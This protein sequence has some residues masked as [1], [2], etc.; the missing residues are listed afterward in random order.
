MLA[1]HGD[2]GVLYNVLELLSARQHGIGAK[3][4]VVDDGGYGILR[5][6][7]E[8]AYGRTSKVDLAQPDFPALAALAR[9]PGLRGRAR[10]RSPARSPRR[11]PST[12]P[13]SSTCPRRSCTRGDALMDLALTPELVEI[14][15]RSRRFCDE[16]LVP[17]ELAVRAGRRPRPPRRSP[18]SAAASSTPGCTP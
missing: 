8:G 13:P 18:A 7:Q 14:Q 9:R 3:L 15:E 16:H 5:V 1:V 11:S 6:Y 2:G 10:A 4:L 12:A 17:V